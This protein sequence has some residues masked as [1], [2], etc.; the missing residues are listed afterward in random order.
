MPSA[1]HQFLDT[2]A[3]SVNP[4]L[5]LLAIGVAGIEWR[6][7]GWKRAAIFAGATALGLIGIYAI[8]A[9]G[10]RFQWWQQV[11]G[12]Y[13]LHSAFA[14]SMGTSLVFWRPRWRVALVVGVLAYLVMIVLMGYHSTVDVVSAALVGVV[15]TL[16][17]HLAAKRA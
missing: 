1:F 15:V 2:L 6:R 17:W 3:D 16:P 4:I 12:D 8:A 9:L 14:T 11:G 5:A 13:S 7:R 10:Q